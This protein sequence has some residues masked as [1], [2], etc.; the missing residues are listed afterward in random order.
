ML[1]KARKLTR[2]GA[3]TLLVGLVFLTAITLFYVGVV[4]PSEIPALMF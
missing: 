4:S 2:G 1:K 3:K